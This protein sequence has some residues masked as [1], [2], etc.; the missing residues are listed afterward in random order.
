[1]IVE[2]GLTFWECPP[3]VFFSQFADG[4]RVVSIPRQIQTDFVN[5][6]TL[7]QGT[8]KIAPSKHT[9]DDTLK[10]PPPPRK[11]L[12]RS[13]VIL[14]ENPLCIGSQGFFKVQKWR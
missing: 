12:L 7:V 6:A 9:C 11:I 2:L 3:P 8:L 10:P 4:V 5:L 14:N 1:M 13:L